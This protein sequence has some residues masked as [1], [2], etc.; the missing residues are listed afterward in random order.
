MKPNL[1]VRRRVLKLCFPQNGQNQVIKPI[2]NSRI[3]LGRGFFY[4]KKKQKNTKSKLVTNCRRKSNTKCN[5]KTNLSK[6]K[7]SQEVTTKR[8]TDKQTKHSQSKNGKE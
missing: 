4:R 6:T 8:T 7:L 3:N 2:K 1:K 5:I